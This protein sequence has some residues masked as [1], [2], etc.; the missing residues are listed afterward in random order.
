MSKALKRWTFSGGKKVHLF[1][2]FY[3]LKIALFCIFGFN[4]SHKKTLKLC[5]YQ[6]FALKSIF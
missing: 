4:Y 2:N 6:G 3:M 5:E 1:P